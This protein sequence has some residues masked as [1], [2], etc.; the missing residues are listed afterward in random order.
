[1]ATVSDP[2][3]TICFFQSGHG[4]D[5]ANTSVPYLVGLVD[6]MESTTVDQIPECHGQFQP[7]FQGGPPVG[8]DLHQSY[9][10]MILEEVEKSGKILIVF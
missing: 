10:Q 1:M 5:V 3:T 4:D 2:P 9:T 8:V 6:L 7:R